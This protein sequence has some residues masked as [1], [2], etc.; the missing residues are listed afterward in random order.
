MD[1]KSAYIYGD[2]LFFTLGPVAV[3][4]VTV[5]LLDQSGHKCED[6]DG[7]TGTL[8][9]YEEFTEKQSY[10]VSVSG[11]EMT[12]TLGSVLPDYMGLYTA[13][14]ILGEYGVRGWIEVQK[15]MSEQTDYVVTVSE[16]AKYLGRYVTGGYLSSEDFENWMLAQSLET[17][18]T[19]WNEVPGTKEYTLPASRY[20]PKIR[21][22]AVGF[23]LQVAGT[24]LQRERMPVE[25][26][27]MS[28][29][30]KN[31]AEFYLQ[32][33]QKLIGRFRDWA[34]FQGEREMIKDGFG[35]A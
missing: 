19:E 29:D 24:A 31:R 5:M 11:S 8:S 13:E 14:L 6:F 32:Q 3:D 17:A 28:V 18:V 26:G 30:D 9:L 12:V 33:G 20:I 16:I 2:I 27:E 7:Q 1:D 22:G 23:A 35:V 25:T 4:S 15:R 34:S 10:D 21:D